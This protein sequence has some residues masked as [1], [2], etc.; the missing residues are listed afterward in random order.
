MYLQH[1][2]LIARLKDTRK[3]VVLILLY[4]EQN[5]GTVQFLIGGHEAKMPQRSLYEDES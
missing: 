3:V 1:I 2:T 4:G 5:L